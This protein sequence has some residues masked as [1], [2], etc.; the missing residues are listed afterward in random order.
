[1]VDDEEHVPVADRTRDGCRLTSSPSSLTPS[2]LATADG[3]RSGSET[4]AS[5]TS[6]LSATRS[7]IARRAA[8]SASAVFPIP[9]GPTRL[10]TR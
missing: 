4:A 1:M 7:G 5:S 3:T 10:T 2:T 6:T 9:P 8:S